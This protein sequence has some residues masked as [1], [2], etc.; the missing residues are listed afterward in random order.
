M[1]PYSIVNKRCISLQ[2]NNCTTEFLNMLLKCTV[3]IKG[4]ID[5]IPIDIYRI[6]IATFMLK[7]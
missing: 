1:E 3:N 4:Y 2:N 7:V 5:C 6:C